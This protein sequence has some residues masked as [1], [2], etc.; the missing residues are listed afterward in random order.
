MREIVL[1]AGGLLRGSS[2]S[3]L[4]TFLRRRRSIYRAEASTMSQA[5]SYDDSA[6]T[7]ADIRCMIEECDYYCAGEVP[8]YDLATPGL[9]TSAERRPPAPAPA[10]RLQGVTFDKTNTLTVGQPCV[11]DVV[12][13]DAPLSEDGLVW[14]VASAEQLSERPLARAVVE[15]AKERRLKLAAPTTFEAIPGHGL[16]AIVDGRTILVG[17]HKLMRDSNI[18]L[19]G[20]G[21]RAARLEGAGRTVAYAAVDGVVAG[22]IVFAHAIRPT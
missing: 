12:P 9:G 15:R 3:A 5:V 2:G 6:I 21:E 22:I 10:A 18:T 11:V 19:D 20:L 16:R 13:V 17:N 1:E 8:P 7:E 4:E 14:L